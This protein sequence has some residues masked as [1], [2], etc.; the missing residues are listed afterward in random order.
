MMQ[1]VR[2]ELT[3]P[4]DKELERMRGGHLERSKPVLQLFVDLLNNGIRRPCGR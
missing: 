2:K 1:L 3:L 4:K